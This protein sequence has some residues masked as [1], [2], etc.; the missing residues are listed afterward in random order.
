MSLP[1][2]RAYKASQILIAQ[3][4][5]CLPPKIQ[6]LS[7]TCMTLTSCPRAPK[8]STPIPSYTDWPQ[9]HRA[10]GKVQTFHQAS[11]PKKPRLL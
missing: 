7:D 3:F 4:R 6:D 10:L 5:L 8:A 2:H 9:K 1:I 11:Y